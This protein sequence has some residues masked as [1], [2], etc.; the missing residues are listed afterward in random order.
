MESSHTPGGAKA[1]AYT[2]EERLALIASI[3]GVLFSKIKLIMKNALKNTKLAQNDHIVAVIELLAEQVVPQYCVQ[4][5]AKGDKLSL[6]HSLVY[7]LA[8]KTQSVF[9]SGVV[10]TC[11]D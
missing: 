6:M 3:N 8:S 10:R 4:N 5:M 2:D 1:P 9:T 11:I 7:L